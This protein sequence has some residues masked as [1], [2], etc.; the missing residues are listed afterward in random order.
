MKNVLSTIQT[1]AALP[2]RCL[3]G[4]L[5]FPATLVDAIEKLAVLK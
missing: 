2:G 4:V 3:R 5:N 1:L